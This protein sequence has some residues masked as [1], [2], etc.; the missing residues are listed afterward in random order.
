MRMGV[1]FIFY[2]EGVI[3]VSGRVWGLSRDGAWWDGV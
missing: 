1:V 3:V 2:Y